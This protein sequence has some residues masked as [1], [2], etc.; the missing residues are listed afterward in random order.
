MAGGE[1]ELDYSLQAYFVDI[2][3]G[4]LMRTNSL[5]LDEIVHALLPVHML[6]VQLANL[7]ARL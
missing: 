5:A 2:A 1:A 3:Q 6:S 4:K 7:A